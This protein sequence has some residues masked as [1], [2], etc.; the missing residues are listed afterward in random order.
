MSLRTSIVL[1][2]IGSV[3]V[4]LACIWY[5][6]VEGWPTIHVP[7]STPATRV[8]SIV[9]VMA[10]GLGV[11]L[12]AWLWLR[13]RSRRR[14]QKSKPPRATDSARGPAVAVPGDGGAGAA[15]AT[16]RTRLPGADGCQA[17]G[18]TWPPGWSRSDQTIP[19]PLPAIPG[20]GLW[21]GLEV[22]PPDLP[23]RPTQVL[24]SL[25]RGAQRRRVAAGPARRSLA[26]TWPG[27]G[28]EA[29]ARPQPGHETWTAGERACTQLPGLDEINN[30]R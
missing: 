19:F 21:A 11:W 5:G 22:V 25:C 8:G 4:A 6:V 18:S 26:A 27:G 2:A 9:G 16:G 30:H 13:P 12:V 23:G 14:R 3:L 24:P 20:G 17:A 29:A 28:V 7:W 10:I 15:T 1:T